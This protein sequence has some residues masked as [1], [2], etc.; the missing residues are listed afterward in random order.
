M[1][2]ILVIV[3]LALGGCAMELSGNSEG[4][5][6]DSGGMSVKEAFSKAEAH[7]QKFG[8]NAQITNINTMAGGEATFRCLKG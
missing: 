1:R 6:M 4:G 7:C 8:R 3:A 5:V 2:Q